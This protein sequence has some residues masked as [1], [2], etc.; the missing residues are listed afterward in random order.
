[1]CTR[2]RWF[3]IGISLWLLTP[4]MSNGQ[5]ATNFYEPEMAGKFTNIHPSK[6]YKT[7]TI[8][9]G[10]FED[11]MQEDEVR[12]QQGKPFRYGQPLPTS[13]SFKDGNWTTFKDKKIWQVMVTSEDAYTLGVMFSRLQLAPEAELFVYNPTQTIVVGPINSE[14]LHY[15]QL[16][17]DFV[18]DDSV[19]I[20]LIEPI[21]TKMP[22]TLYVNNII[23]RYCDPNKLEFEFLIESP[24]GTS[25]TDIPEDSVQKI[26]VN[27]I[28][29]SSTMDFYL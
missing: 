10:S 18:E 15:N 4:T 17:T 9:H 11:R 25:L 13:I 28:S 14:N 12:L 5:I 7:I 26:Y 24:F 2:L 29:V 22:S 3:A 23:H 16:N 27:V 1:M 19:I 6:S 21:N 20:E 8:Q